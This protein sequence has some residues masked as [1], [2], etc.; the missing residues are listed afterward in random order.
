MSG[1]HYHYPSFARYELLFCSRPRALAARVL[2]SYILVSICLALYV[3]DNGY[4]RV[5]LYIFL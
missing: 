3:Y 4:V 1:V 5:L 2:S